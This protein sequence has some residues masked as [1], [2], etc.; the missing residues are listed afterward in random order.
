VDHVPGE[1]SRG[2]REMLRAEENPQEPVEHIE[3]FLRITAEHPGVK[4][5]GLM[6]TDTDLDR[7]SRW[8]QSGVRS[9]YHL[10]EWWAGV[11]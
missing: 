1:D 5:R 2:S 8:Y 6:F 10:S 7:R 3:L 11:G 9:S 4:A